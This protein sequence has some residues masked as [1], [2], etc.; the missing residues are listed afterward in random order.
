MTK[1]KTTYT[2]DINRD[3]IPLIAEIER[4]ED[5]IAEVY[6]KNNVFYINLYDGKEIELDIFL[7]TIVRAKEGLGGVKSI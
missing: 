1:L 7:K 5:F 4:A 6:K 2:S 3:E